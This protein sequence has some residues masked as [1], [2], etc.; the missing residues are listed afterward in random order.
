MCAVTCTIVILLFIANHK[1]LPGVDAYVSVRPAASS[2]I[3]TFHPKPDEI[4]VCRMPRAYQYGLDY[5]FGSELPEWTAENS[6]AKFLFCNS[7]SLRDPLL[8]GVPGM[9]QSASAGDE[10]IFFVVLHPAADK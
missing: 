5:Y 9:G 8:S 3:S 10:K 4:A 7:E 1:V 2:L 6:K